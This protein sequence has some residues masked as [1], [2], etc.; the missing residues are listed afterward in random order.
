M[1]KRLRTM[2]AA[3]VATRA[4]RRVMLE[5]WRR[6]KIWEPA[7]LVAAPATSEYVLPPLDGEPG[8]AEAVAEADRQLAGSV[9]LLGQT[10]STLDTEWRLDPQSGIRSPL[11]FGPLLDYRDSATGGNTRNVWELSRHQ[12]LVPVALA[13]AATREQAY[14]DHVQGQLE[15]W[16]RQDPF[17]MGVNWNSALEFGL[18]L[19]SWVWIGRFL[20]GSPAWDALFGATG[21]LWDSIYRHQFAIERLYSVG[22][23]ANNHLI[24]EMAG[25][26]IAATEWPVFARSRDWARRAYRVLV[27]E[28]ARQYYPSGLNREQAYAYHL[29]ATELLALAAAEGARYGRP[30]PLDAVAAVGRAVEA[31][32]ALSGPGAVRPAYGDSDD[33]I[34]VGLPGSGDVLGRLL[35]V[36]EGLLGAPSAGSGGGVGSC[37]TGARLILSGVRPAAV[38]DAL[39]R[40][41]AQRSAGTFAVEDAGLFRLVSRTDGLEVVCLADAGELG[42]LSIA[43]HGHADCLS[44]TLSAGDEELLVDPGTYTYHYDPEARAYFRGTAAHNTVLVDGEDQSEPAGPFLWVRKARPTVHRWEPGENGGLLVASHDGYQRLSSPV[45][46]QRSLALEGRTTLISDILEGD[47]VHE[48]E[49]RLHAAPHCE[50]RLDGNA[51]VVEGRHHRLVVDLDRTLEWELLTAQGRGGWYSCCFNRRVPTTTLVGRATLRLPVCL[52]HTATVSR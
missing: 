6:K 5:G 17:P 22:S 24:G 13:F 32:A 3:E 26:F 21:S 49:W 33:G 20:A 25:L 7:E 34:A 46:H 15:S 38:P 35:D 14:A 29:F 12:H 27:A 30:F 2:S 4:R 37:A 48:I 31:A 19:I 50:V 41:G 45:R 18:R 39:R 40:S 52:D 23:S 8:V 36:A 51:C 28:T 1:A 9:E 42:Y 11:D 10:F 16:L 47:G 43:A 44:F